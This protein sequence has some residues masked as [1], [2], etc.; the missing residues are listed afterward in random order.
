MISTTASIPSATDVILFPSITLRISAAWT[1]R[2][3]LESA[4]MRRGSIA[5]ESARFISAHRAAR[6]PGE[7]R[8]LIISRT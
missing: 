6:L 8:S 2:R 3:S 1:L 5:I 4:S 7:Y